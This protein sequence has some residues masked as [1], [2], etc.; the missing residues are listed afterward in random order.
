[1]MAE[2]QNSNK[3]LSSSN[4]SPKIVKKLES[5]EYDTSGQH[6]RWAGTRS[7]TFLAALDHCREFLLLG[8]QAVCNPVNLVETSVLELS[9]SLAL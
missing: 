2:S 7:I 5:Y 1:M 3:K 8:F 4:C 6:A 9:A